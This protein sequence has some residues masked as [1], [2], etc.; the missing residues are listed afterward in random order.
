MNM[1]SFRMKTRQH[2]ATGRF[3]FSDFARRLAMSRDLSM[4]SALLLLAACA[5]DSTGPETTTTTN[6]PASDFAGVGLEDPIR[7]RGVDDSSV[8][9]A[10]G[11]PVRR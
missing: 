10:G 2:G 5:G 9:A 11:D 7:W 1:E 3:R 4:V 8:S 6:Q